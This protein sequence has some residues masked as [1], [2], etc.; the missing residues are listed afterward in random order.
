ME[1]MR[2]FML[3]RYSDEPFNTNE[4]IWPHWSEIPFHAPTLATLGAVFAMIA[5]PA[6][7]L[8]RRD[9]RAGRQLPRP[10]A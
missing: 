2:A 3:C 5:A 1:M 8:A 4:V 10:S 9:G 6:I 7:W